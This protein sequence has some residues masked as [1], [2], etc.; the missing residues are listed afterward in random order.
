MCPLA[1]ERTPRLLFCSY[2]RL[3][4]PS[5]GAA[6]ATC[7]LLELLAARGWACGT[8][9][10]PHLDFEQ[11]PPSTEVLRARGLPY[12]ARSGRAG[13]RPFSLFQLVQ[14]GVAVSV[15]GP[16]RS[17]VTALTLSPGLPL[18][19]PGWTTPLGR[20]SFLPQLDGPPSPAQG[21]TL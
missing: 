21:R 14:G 1:A 2:H 10:G 17:R 9:C 15:F 20:D 8:F 16:F 13:D 5:S 4:D 3:V 7:D 19:S 6:L 18:S 11:A 12:T